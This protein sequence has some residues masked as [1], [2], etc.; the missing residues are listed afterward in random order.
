MTNFDYNLNIPNGPD[1]PSAD[2][3]LMQTNTNSTSGIIGVDHVT[4]ENS[5]GGY[6]TDIHMIPQSPPAPISGIGQLFTQNVTVNS[7]TDTQLFFLTGVGGTSQLTGSNSSTNGYQ[8]IGGVLIQWGYVTE[9]VGS[10]GQVLF[11]G[12]NINFPKACFN[13][14]IT[15]SRSVTAPA[16]TNATVYVNQSTFS[17]L[18]PPNKSSFWWSMSTSAPANG[19]DQLYW[20]AIGN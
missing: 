11:S 6:H 10:S 2:W 12:N 7:S 9:L 17:G 4:F 5:N 8:W 19:Y 18:N 13:V 15:L 3:P 14:S 16:V 20:I 1:N